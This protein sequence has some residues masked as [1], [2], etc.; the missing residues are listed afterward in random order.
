M[1]HG[2]VSNHGFVDGNKRTALYLMELLVRR[3]GFEF[4]KE[5]DDMIADVITSVAR[6]ETGY[7]D[8]AE[9]FHRRLV[10]SCNR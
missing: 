3:S 7:D 4:I 6:G 9:W 10:R 8:L 5:D 2:V 1:I